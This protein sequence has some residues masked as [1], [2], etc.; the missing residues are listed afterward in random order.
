MF[1]VIW[2]QRAVNNLA[3]IWSEGDSALRQEITKAANI[4]ERTLRDD[5]I[6]ASESR[7]EGRRVMFVPPLGVLFQ[8]D[9][10]SGR[11]LVGRIWRIR[12]PRRR[13]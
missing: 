8:V 5:A 10:D 7:E 1:E 11:V 3:E 13:T 2:L 6:G 12:P 9:Q 4:I